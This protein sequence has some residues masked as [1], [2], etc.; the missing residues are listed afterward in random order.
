MVGQT[1][2][3]G[4]NIDFS[5]IF[6]LNYIAMAI[7]DVNIVRYGWRNRMLK[8]GGSGNG[9]T[10]ASNWTWLGFVIIEL[11]LLIRESQHLFI[12]LFLIL[13][14]FICLSTYCVS[15]AS[16]TL[17]E[18]LTHN[19]K[20]SFSTSVRRS[21]LS[22]SS[23]GTLREEELW[24]LWPFSII[25]LRCFWD[26]VFFPLLLWGVCAS[27]VAAFAWRLGVMLLWCLSG[28]RT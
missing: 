26:N 18:T 21:D 5:T 2:K 12:A 25:L 15:V 19:N 1:L 13:M 7:I 27:L 22:N 9:C 28:E 10:G 20:A 11:V 4:W 24:R 14:I 16:V 17:V 6:L 3:Q 8:A 23:F